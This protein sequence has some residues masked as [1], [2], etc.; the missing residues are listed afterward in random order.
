MSEIIAK[1]HPRQFQT[2]LAVC[3]KEHLGKTFVDDKVDFKISDHFYNGEEVSEEEL[4][5]M[6]KE[7]NSI[8]LFGNNCVE[9][10]E[11]E[12]LITKSSVI[13][14][15]GIKHVQIYQL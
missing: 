4:I 13:L 5:E 6:V 10:L 3:D 7:A 9:I 2:I 8:N 14:I 1:V 11:R 12:G 15:K